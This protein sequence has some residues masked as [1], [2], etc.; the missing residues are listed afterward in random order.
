MMN[1]P[2]ER[3]SG[4]RQRDRRP[5]KQSFQ[6]SRL[7]D[8]IS[9]TQNGA[10]KRRAVLLCAEGGTRTPTGLHPLR[11]ERSASTSSTT[12]ARFV[13]E[14]RKLRPIQQPHKLP[15]PSEHSQ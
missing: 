12:S 14:T 8:R 13:N 11:P 7:S 1:R 3:G 15:T 5:R 9:D 4:F 2:S 6:S 10:S